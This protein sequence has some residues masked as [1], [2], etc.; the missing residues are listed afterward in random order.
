MSACTGLYCWWNSVIM[1]PCSVRAGGSNVSLCLPL[2]LFPLFSL[3]ECQGESKYTC[4]LSL[5][6]IPS[7]SSSSCTVPDYRVFAC[8]PACL[9]AQRPYAYL[10]LVS[11]PWSVNVGPTELFHSR[12]AALSELQRPAD[13]Q[14]TH[15]EMWQHCTLKRITGRMCGHNELYTQVYI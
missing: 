5:S 12:S 6:Q 8:L 10:M 9:L 13:L 15:G 11:R 2:S 3:A 4:I 7:P 1:S 14:C